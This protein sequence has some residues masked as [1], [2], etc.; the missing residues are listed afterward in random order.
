MPEFLMLALKVRDSGAMQIIS[1]TTH[2]L[3]RHVKHLPSNLK[4]P[5]AFKEIHSGQ[6]MQV[7]QGVVHAAARVEISPLVHLKEKDQLRELCPGIG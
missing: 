1:L 3:L 6:H 2:G 4:L 7:K 5:R